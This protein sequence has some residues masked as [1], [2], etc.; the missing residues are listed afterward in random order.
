MGL[1]HREF[2]WYGQARPY[3]AQLRPTNRENTPDEDYYVDPLPCHQSRSERGRES[4]HL[5]HMIDVACRELVVA[6]EKLY[7]AFKEGCDLGT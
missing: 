6:P 7:Q 5:Q 3:H 1:P 4:A 2:G